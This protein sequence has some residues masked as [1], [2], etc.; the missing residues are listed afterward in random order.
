MTYS[1]TKIPPVDLTQLSD[2]ITTAGLPTPNSYD[3]EDSALVIS[4]DGALNSDQQ[5]TLGSVVAAHTP[6][7]GYVSLATQ[8]AIATLTAYLNNSNN[9]IAA[10]ARAAVVSTLAPNLPP[11]LLATINA[12]IA[13]ALGSP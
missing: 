9:V 13:T 11:N 2:E 4:F 5:V 3:V 1:F 6:L 7:P 10:T 8:A 12:K